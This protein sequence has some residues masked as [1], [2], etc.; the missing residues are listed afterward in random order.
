ML[1]S[2]VRNVKARLVNFD[3]IVLKIAARCYISGSLWSWSFY[4]ISEWTWSDLRTEADLIDSLLCHYNS[5]H[6]GLIKKD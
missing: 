3:G 5:Y 4:F 1:P 2:N 6:N